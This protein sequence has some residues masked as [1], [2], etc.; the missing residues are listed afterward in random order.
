MVY[1]YIV[2]Q[3]RSGITGAAVNR[4]RNVQLKQ[5]LQAGPVF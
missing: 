4:E 1:C 3:E 2:R 5:H